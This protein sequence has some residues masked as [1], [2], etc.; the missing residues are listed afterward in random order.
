MIGTVDCMYLLNNI[1]IDHIAGAINAGLT[2]FRLGKYCQI[3]DG[4]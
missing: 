1:E 3:F 4:V 2:Q